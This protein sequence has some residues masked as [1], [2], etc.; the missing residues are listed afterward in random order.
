MSVVG[1]QKSTPVSGFSA[2]L[3]GCHFHLFHFRNLLTVVI[4]C[5]FGVLVSVY[6]DS[7]KSLEQRISCKLK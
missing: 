4:F 3:A 5:C 2:G 6:R 7:E 1:Q